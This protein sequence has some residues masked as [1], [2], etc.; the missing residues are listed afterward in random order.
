MDPAFP[1]VVGEWAAEQVDD[2]AKVW[3]L[4][5]GSNGKLEE[6][7]DPTF[8]ETLEK[9]ETV[10]QLADAIAASAARRHIEA[11]RVW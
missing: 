4:S 2:R 6:R 5:R 7:L 1:D 11:S 9:A 8:L 3:T 10:E